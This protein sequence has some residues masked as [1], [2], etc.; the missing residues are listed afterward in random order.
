MKKII[1]WFL[2]SLMTILMAGIVYGACTC[3]IL[4][5]ATT[6]GTAST[7]F[8]GSAIN[9]SVN[10]TACSSNLDFNVTRGN[11]TLSTG[12]PIG[13]VIFN[14]TQNG[15]NVSYMNFTLNTL[16]LSDDKSYTATVTLRNDSDN[17]AGGTC[18]KVLIPDNTVPVL[19]SGSPGDLYK[20]VDG[21]VGV[22]INCANT[23]S[24]NLYIENNIYSSMTE[25]SDV[26]NLSITM[27]SAGFHSWYVIASDGLNKTTSS[28]LKFEVRKPGG[29]VLDEQ[30]RLVVDTTGATVPTG[31]NNLGGIGEFIRDI[32]S[33]P[34]RII[35]AI[36]NM[37]T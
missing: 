18:T 16:S 23:S 9:V 31:S 24:A 14:G 32:L 27:D 22:G 13:S 11:L 6:A 33:I 4:N 21:D 7:Y 12:T 19:T 36:L 26:C 5:T 15:D 2:M 3:T 30:G 8:R 10:I 25:S 1:M 17:S 28:T 37:F 20:D 35:Q 29:Y 34:V